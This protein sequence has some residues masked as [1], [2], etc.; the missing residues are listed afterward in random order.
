[1]AA[2]DD[3]RAEAVVTGLGAVTPYGV[4][5]DAF[6]EGLLSGRNTGRRVTAFDPQGYPTQI[7]CDITGFDP[8]A[9]LPRKLV[10][11]VDPFAQYALIAA[12]EALLDA[13]LIE[14]GEGL[15][16]PLVSG[17]DPTRVGTLVASGVGGMSEMTT[18]YDRLR[19][20]GPKQVRP[21]MAIAMPLNMGGGQ[22]AIRH[23]L[24]G[25]A[26]SAVSACASGTDAVGMGLDMLRSGRAD[27]I[28]AGGAEAAINS[29]VLAG[30]AAAGAL[31]RRNDE[32]DRAS[33]PFDV[34]RDGFV[35]GEGA[36][37]LV[38]ET[39]EH[40][41]ARGATPLGR[42][43]GYGSSDD[44][45]HA[46]APS[47]DGS[48]AARALRTALSDAG[49]QP[50]EID[51]VNAHGTSTPTNDPSEAAALRA[52]FGEHVHQLAAT[53]TKSAI[54]HLLGGAGGIEAVATVQAMCQGTVP[55]SQN[56]DHQDPECELDVVAGQPR[57]VAMQTALSE[58]FG[59]GGH[60]SVLAFRGA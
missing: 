32:P 54:G 5:V 26:F 23:N 30:F 37:M 58:S 21:F 12:E 33:R 19:E 57:R 9:H 34:D 55:P 36:G 22:I 41:A 20:G 46:T 29:L 50:T 17:V 52:V 10:R 45:Y 18:Q 1:M 14:P 31:S 39:P 28:L 59:F 3:P 60:N 15:A 48:G 49:L 6:W 25:P 35:M 47:P 44:A 42:L 11:Q 13:K 27:V 7:A 16:L 53:S 56:L 43:A 2:T 4:G 24:Q 40:A 38:L 8:L 51:H